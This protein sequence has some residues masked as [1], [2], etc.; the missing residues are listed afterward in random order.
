MLM[1]L[2]Q[3]YNCPRDN[4]LLAKCTATTSAKKYKIILKL[5]NELHTKNQNR[6]KI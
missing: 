3:V 2:S 5:S 1:D 6:L 4:I